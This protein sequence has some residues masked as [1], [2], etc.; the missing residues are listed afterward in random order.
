[1]EP[2]K[3]NTINMSLGMD[4]LLISSNEY[5]GTIETLERK[6]ENDDLGNDE[7]YKVGAEEEEEE[8]ITK[9]KESEAG[10]ILT[11]NQRENAK[12][13]NIS[14]KSKVQSPRVSFQ[15]D[16]HIKV[17]DKVPM[18][19]I[20]QPSRLLQSK[21]QFNFSKKYQKTFEKMD[22]QSFIQSGDKTYTQMT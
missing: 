2:P 1:M 5:S 13:Y 16:E 12:T 15:K 19:N 17:E 20:F 11:Q 9:S 6:K 21:N 10:E 22:K 8:E 3:L 7:D 4:K 14:I 18:H